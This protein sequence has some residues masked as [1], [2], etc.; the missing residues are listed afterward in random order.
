MFEINNFLAHGYRDEQRASGKIYKV[1]LT[2][3]HLFKLGTPI[4]H[5]VDG[6]CTE[7][8]V[9][10]ELHMDQTGTTVFYKK[11]PAML[12]KKTA[13]AYETLYNLTMDGVNAPIRRDTQRNRTGMDGA[14][15]LMSGS[16][17]DID[18]IRREHHD[19]YGFTDDYED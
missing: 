14:M 16:N 10:V 18:E 8:V 5:M 2:G 13:E 17:R 6:E 9:P 4:P 3:I 7:L 12:S 1:R 11:V 15:R 19:D